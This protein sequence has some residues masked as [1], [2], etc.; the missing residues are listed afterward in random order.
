MG[1]G[2]NW[3]FEEDLILDSSWEY[4]PETTKIT[5]GTLIQLLDSISLEESD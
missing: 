1:I 5:V 3:E 4:A 2:K